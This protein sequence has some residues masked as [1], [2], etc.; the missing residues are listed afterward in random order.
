[1]ALPSNLGTREYKK[2]VETD[3]G[4][5]AVRTVG[6][7]ASQAGGLSQASGSAVY[8]A[9]PSGTNAD[10][11][12][13]YASATTLTVTG[14][15]FTF[16]QYDIESIEQ[17]PTSGTSTLYSD[18][19]DFSVSGTTIT[20]TGAAFA[21]TDEFIVKLVDGNKAYDSANDSNRVEIINRK[22]DDMPMQTLA[23]VTNETNG[24]NER[25]I[26]LSTGYDG[27][28]I[29]FEKTG[30][31]DSVTLTVEGAVQDEGVAAASLATQDITQY[32]LG[33]ATAASTA[34]SY[35]A[36]A[37]LFLLE[38]QTYNQVKVKTVSAGGAN[39]A[40]YAIYYIKFKR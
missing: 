8:Y 24:T 34:A 16:T 19:A 6:D 40:G 21:A 2:F 22:G 3:S 27:L 35:T 37:T 10:G 1:M 33:I 5:V 38:G 29:A 18:K 12:S 25:Y 26:S 28:I 20:V 15:P 13:A 14:L 9:K 32:G 4:D 36:D 11:T 23:D 31:A 39:D 7:T 30:G 17:I